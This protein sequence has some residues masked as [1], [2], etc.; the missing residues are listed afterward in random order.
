MAATLGIDEAEARRGLDRLSALA[1][2]RST[3]SGPGPLHTVRPEIGLEA[4]IARREEQLAAEQARLASSKAA[5][6]RLAAEL[7]AGNSAPGFE[8]LYGIEAVR[9]RL[10]ALHRDVREEVLTFAPGGA[11]TAENLEAARPLDEALLSRGVR[12]R[13]VYLDS[14]RNS[15]DSVAYAQ[16][17]SER[18]REART[19]PALPVRLIVIDRRLAVLPLDED[20]SGAGAVV[21]SG[22]G[23]ISALCALFESVW[24]QGEPFG[25]PGTPA[26]EPL[27]PGERATLRFLAMGLTDEAIAKRL[28]VSPRTT[29]R[30]STTLMERLGARSRFQAGVEAARRKW[31]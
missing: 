12:M 26:H 14:V 18:G 23:A 4:L 10:V 2:I 3:G 16:W 7:P 9:D 20:D 6:A 30:T 13:T 11:Q 24:E 8:R 1:L 19:V 25:T 5:V 21:V 27:S 31:L 28:G 17:L 29:R 15:P 22:G